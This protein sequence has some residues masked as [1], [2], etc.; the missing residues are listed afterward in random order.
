MGDRGNYYE[1]SYPGLD[2]S[3]NAG[4]QRLQQQIHGQMSVHPDYGNGNISHHQRN[5]GPL[6][7]SSPSLTNF[8]SSF[9]LI[10]CSPPPPVCNRSSL[11]VKPIVVQPKTSHDLINSTS[12]ESMDN[13]SS[14]WNQEE[15]KRRPR[16]ERKPISSNMKDDKYFERRHRNNDAA[17]RS[18]DA[19]KKRMD[20]IMQRSNIL[21]HENLILRAQRSTLYDQICTMREM[22]VKRGKRLEFNSNGGATSI[23]K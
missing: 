2:M 6:S 17:K 15:E 8:T 16:S 5:C 22:A 18:R 1:Q 14:L 3:N 11:D 9:P 21:E 23:G 10:G 20:S 12:Y 19:R 13:S 7:S 4:Y